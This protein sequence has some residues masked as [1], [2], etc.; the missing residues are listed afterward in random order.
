MT[1]VI[2]RP[3]KG[4]KPLFNEDQRRRAKEYLKSVG[5]DIDRMPKLIWPDDAVSATQEHPYAPWKFTTRSDVLR[6]RKERMQHQLW[7]KRDYGTTEI[8]ALY[9]WVFWCPGAFG[10]AFRGLW[11]Y[12]VGIG[13]KYNGGGI[14]GNVVGRL[15]DEVISLFPLVDKPLFPD[16]RYYNQWQEEFIKKYPTRKKRSGKAPIWAEVEGNQV[17]KIL[18][19]AQVAQVK[20]FKV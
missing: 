15:L 8:R 20:K 9:V 10:F 3:P 19:R 18:S 1:T 7:W 5:H 11:T 14:K 4:S 12:L 17:I 2:K 6:A 13:R 16:W